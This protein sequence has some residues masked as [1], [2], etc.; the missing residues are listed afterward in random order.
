[1]THAAPDPCTAVP[2]HPCPTTV[3]HHLSPTKEGAVG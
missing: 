2:T 3:S 1:M